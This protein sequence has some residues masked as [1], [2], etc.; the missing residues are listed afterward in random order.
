MADSLPNSPPEHSASAFEP[1]NLGPGRGLLWLGIA[2]EFVLGVL[3]FGLAWLLGQPVGEHVHWGLHGV[4][5][6]LAVCV[7][8]SLFFFVCVRWPVGPLEPIER[9]VREVVRPLFSRCAAWQLALLCL[10]AGFG[11]EL[12]FRGALQGALCQWLPPWAGIAVA[13]LL[14]GMM[15]PI[16]VGYV[17]LATA[18]GAYLGWAYLATEDLMVVV[19][20][21]AVYDF[22]ALLFVTR[23]P[24]T[25][26]GHSVRDN[27][28]AS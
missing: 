21:H 17:V 25:I 28:G 16:T 13:S 23:R 19:V 22:L 18:M 26:I 6:G 10:T 27:V 20:A 24:I 3:G 5:L 2:F 1:L 4:G 8:M 15:H 7:P 9:F 11:E 14:F 12:L